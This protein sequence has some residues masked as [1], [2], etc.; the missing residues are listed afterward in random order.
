MPGGRDERPAAVEPGETVL[1]GKTYLQEMGEQI[2]ILD[3]AV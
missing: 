3:H 1:L 2:D